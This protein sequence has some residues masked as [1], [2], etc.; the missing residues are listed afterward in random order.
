MGLII[1]AIQKCSTQ[2][3]SKDDEEY[4]RYNICDPD[5]NSLIKKTEKIENLDCYR[6][7]TD[8]FIGLSVDQIM[9]PLCKYHLPKAEEEKLSKMMNESS[10][11]AIFNKIEAYHSLVKDVY[12]VDIFANLKEMNDQIDQYILGVNKNRYYH[13]ICRRSNFKEIVLDIL[14]Y[15]TGFNYKS[16]INKTYSYENWGNNQNAKKRL[17]D[18][19]KI[20]YDEQIRIDELNRIYEEKRAQKEAIENS[21][22][23]DFDL[24]CFQEDQYNYNRAIEQIDWEFNK[25]NDQVKEIQRQIDAERDRVERD[26]QREIENGTYDDHGQPPEDWNAKF[27]R[28]KSKLLLNQDY[29]LEQVV[30]YANYSYT[31]EKIKEYFEANCPEKI[32]FYPTIR[33]SDKEYEEFVQYIRERTSEYDKICLYLETHDY[34]LKNKYALNF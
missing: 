9:C 29:L 15:D 11:R 33:R 5:Y 1:F 26:I 28:E 4:K 21:Y 14:V 27:E 24:Y 10:E 31:K 13:H 22:K 2:C 19:R 7:C 3:K 32:T 20:A 8:G 34:P 16:L 6:Y 17:L 23:N 18:N 25:Y 30:G 12:Q